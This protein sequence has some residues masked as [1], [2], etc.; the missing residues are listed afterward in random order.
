M[1]SFYSN[2][3]PD[4]LDFRRFYGRQKHT[5]LHPVWEETW[6]QIR[7]DADR[8]RIGRS[9]KIKGSYYQGILN[10]KGWIK[11]KTD[12]QYTRGKQ[13]TQY[14]KM[15]DIKDLE[16]MK[17]FTEKDIIRVMLQGDIKVHCS[18]PDFC[19][20]PDTEIKLLDGSVKSIK[21]LKSDFDSGK[22]LWVYSTDEKGD[23][24]PGEVEDI[25]IS[26]TTDKYIKVTLD[27]KEILTTPNHRYML[28]DGS[29][30]RA[31]ELKIN[32]S[33]M[34][35][36]F[37]TSNGYESV[38]L[39][40]TGLYNSVYKIVANEVFGIDD[41]K[42]VRER[43]GEGRISIHHKDFNKNNNYPENLDLTY[44][45]YMKYKSRT[46]PR[47]DKYFDTFDGMLDYFDMANYNHKI[48]KIE[49]I[50]LEQEEPVYDIQVGK[51]HNF[52]VDAGVILHNCY[53][54][55]KY[56][57]YQMGWGIYR[58]DRFPKIRNPRLEG[59]VCKHLLKVFEVYMLNWSKI[60]RDMKKTKYFKKR[61]GI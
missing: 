11:F 55:F 12:S 40:T 44:D 49:V 17:E 3:T 5:P 1:E 27:N 31:D 10:T 43:T 32:T 36:Y 2:I 9:K 58:E 28:R 41:Y 30:L 54:G 47:V 26:G 57:G 35:L 16:D 23:F 29:Y 56:M 22:K 20:H 13:Y 42:K 7:S 37:K 21:D 24:R 38:K 39:N 50:E 19:L 18:C 51:Y 46:T 14:I 52:Y 34:P 4:L 48:A 59:T 25:W 15:L 33:L 45:N 60:A 61:W 8:A 53:K 6:R